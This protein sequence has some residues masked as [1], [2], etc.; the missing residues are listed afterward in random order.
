LG[1]SRRVPGAGQSRKERRSAPSLKSDSAAKRAEG[2]AGELRTELAETRR[3]AELGLATARDEAVAPRR[4]L[5]DQLF[6]RHQAEM[7]A[8]QTKADTETARAEIEADAAREVAESRARGISRLVAQ[9]DDLRA[10]LRRSRPGGNDHP[11]QISRARPWGTEALAETPVL[12]GSGLLPASVEILRGSGCKITRPGSLA[13]ARLQQSPG[14]GPG[15]AVPFQTMDESR[16]GIAPLTTR[17]VR[18]QGGT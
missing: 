5:T 17:G 13:E 12:R 18:A 3:S 6:D 11:A 15:R 4:D 1:R 14:P 16:R 9:I 8:A 7:A 2:I 10:H